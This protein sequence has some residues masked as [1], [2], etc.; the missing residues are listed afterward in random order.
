MDEPARDERSNPQDDDETRWASFTR[1][2]AD[3]MCRLKVR[4]EA[5]LFGDDD[6]YKLPP[7]P[8]NQHRVIP[9]W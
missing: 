9:Q 5:G 3:R 6:P 1:E 4:Y 8:P 7:S 2:E